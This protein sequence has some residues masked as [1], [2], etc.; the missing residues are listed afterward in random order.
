FVLVMV[1]ATQ[2][3]GQPP[4]W[5][6]K[7]DITVM[8]SSVLIR[9]TR[10]K[11]GRGTQ[12]VAI[13]NIII[14][15]ELQ[16][17][18]LERYIA[19]FVDFDR[20]VRSYFKKSKISLPSLREPLDK[21]ARRR[22]IKNIF[23]LSGASKKSNAVK[24]EYYLRKCCSDPY[25]RDSWLL[26][27]FL[28]VQRNEDRAMPKNAVDALV[29]HY[30]ALNAAQ[31]SP[32]S[33]TSVVSFRPLSPPLT[34]TPDTSSNDSIISGLRPDLA[35]RSKSVPLRDQSDE[36][37]NVVP[38]DNELAS[39]HSRRLTAPRAQSVSALPHAVQRPKK[40]LQ[41]F[42]L[43]K[44]LGKGCMGKVL[45][46]KEHKSD[47]LFALKA[48][49]KSW[50]VMQREIEH[51]KAERDILARVAAI[52]HPFLM[53]L[54]YSF[55]SPSQLFLVMDYYVGGDIATQL[56]RYRKFSIEQTRFYAAEILV[57]L[58]ELHRL[59]IVY[60]DL[61]PENI[62]LTASGHIVLTDFGL[63]KQFVASDES[64]VID[65]D[66]EISHRTNTF[67]GTAEYLAPEILQGMEYSFAVDFWSLGTLLYEMITGVTPFWADNHGEMY[68]RVLQDDL[69]FPQG[70]DYTAADMIDGLLQRVPSYRLGW[71]YDGIEELK[72]HLFFHGLNW[73]DV[74]ERRLV[75]PYVPN[76]QSST[77]FSNFDDT[78]LN[79]PTRISLA[80][81]T[82]TPTSTYSTDM[83]DG[84]S[85][86][87]RSVRNS[88]IEDSLSDDESEDSGMSHQQSLEE[89]IQQD[90]PT[91]SLPL[92]NEDSSMTPSSKRHTVDLGSFQ[93]TPRSNMSPVTPSAKRRSAMS[94]PL[95]RVRDLSVGDTE[96]KPLSLVPV[97]AYDALVSSPNLQAKPCTNTSPRTTKAL[98]FRPAPS[99]RTT[100]ASDPT[101]RS[102]A[103]SPTDTK[104]ADRH[105][106][107]RKSMDGAPFRE[108]VKAIIPH[109]SSKTKKFFS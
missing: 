33:P 52:K 26:R 63:S 3:S 5:T 39:Y 60:R 20:K 105:P 59:Q 81:T 30:V 96:R 13:F 40:T 106:T 57:G 19:D 62:L 74:L 103:V 1:E 6:Q 79:M 4:L 64:D 93:A 87:S 47:K 53:R 17:L 24:I 34:S 108:G 75:P 72:S 73:N 84:Y 29:N 91:L 101:S 65:S 10:P 37:V 76:L 27:D 98:S 82:D 46:V 107:S 32:Q 38:N 18:S 45:L 56:A 23:S 48:I 80:T 50:V 42:Q 100:V 90:F 12:T 44:V 36:D 28:A 61:K 58:E 83:F 67:C 95:N 51:T 21:E 25:L 14:E 92:V 89:W 15:D 71:G 16:I 66:L 109:W 35:P 22:S 68:R 8:E 2:E 69:V 7:L 11:D 99:T 78:F 86:T 31:G 102:K 55:Q 88:I 43:L 9:L 94:P 85:F 104:R 77:D 41:D 70:F 54:H 49:S 97:S